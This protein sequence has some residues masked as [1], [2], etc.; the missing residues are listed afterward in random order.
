MSNKSNPTNGMQAENKKC[1]MKIYQHLIITFLCRFFPSIHVRTHSELCVTAQS[2]YL[3]FIGNEIHNNDNNDHRVARTYGSQPDITIKLDTINFHPI[4]V[5]QFFF[6]EE[7]Q[8]H[9]K[10]TIRHAGIE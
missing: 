5:I 6:F 7:S 3:V 4:K 1:V 10:D 8:S 9:S 2:R